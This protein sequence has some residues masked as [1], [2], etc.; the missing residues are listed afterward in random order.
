[1]AVVVAVDRVIALVDVVLVPA[2]VGEALLVGFAVAVLRLG[3]AL[4]RA[5]VARVVALWVR[6]VGGVVTFGGAAEFVVTTMVGPAGPTSVRSAA[7]VV[8][9]GLE[10]VELVASLAPSTSMWGAP[11]S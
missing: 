6:D 1:M 3:G 11:R 10:A 7:V 9:A 4:V 8:A 5:A 2:V